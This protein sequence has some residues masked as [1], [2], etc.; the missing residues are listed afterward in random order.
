MVIARFEFLPDHAQDFCEEGQTIQEMQFEDVVELVAFTK[1]LEHVL[2]E[3]LMYDGENL[4]S[5]RE[6]SKDQ[7]NV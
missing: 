3:V 6:V 7:N 5:L 1:E 2:T 4:I